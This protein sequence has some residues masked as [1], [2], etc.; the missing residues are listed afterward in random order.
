[1]KNTRALVLSAMLSVSALPL[2]AQNWTPVT[3]TKLGDVSGQLVSSGKL[4]FT[5]TDTNDAPIGVQIGGGGQ[6]ATVEV[7]A[8]VTNGVSTVGFQI[9]NPAHTVPAGVLYRI[10]LHDSR[11]DIRI[12]RRVPVGTSFNLDNYSEPASVVPLTGTTITGPFTVLGDFSVTGLCTGCGTGGGGGSGIWGGI[13][14]TLT[15]QGDLAAALALKAPL[16]SAALTGTPTAPTPSTAD[17]TTK[18]ATTAFVKAQGYLAGTT[19][20]PQTKTLIASQWLNAYDATTG[21]LTA[22]QPAFTNLSGLLG[23]TQMPT[24]TGDV[25]NTNCGMT[26]Q[27][28]AITFA[29]IAAATYLGTGTKLLSTSATAPGSPKCA[30]FAADGTIGVAGTGAPCGSGGTGMANP[31]TTLGDVIYGGAA[32]APARLAGNTTTTPLVYQSTGSAGVATAPT[33]GTIDYSQATIINKPTI[34]ADVSGKKYII[35]TPDGALPNAQSLSALATCVLKNTTTTGVLSCALAGDIPNIAESQ[36]T[37]LTT[38][39]AAKVPTSTT[40]N[41]HAL[42]AN[43]TVTQTDVGL[44]S[45]TNDVQ[46]KAA[47]VPNTL[48]SAGQ[49]PV[50]NAGNTAYVPVTVSGDGTLT[51]AGV[52]ALKNSGVSAASYTNPNITVDAQGR[53]TTASNG[54]GGGLFTAANNATMA[55]GT[56]TTTGTCTFKTNT[57][58]Q[59]EADCPIKTP[60]GASNFTSFNNTSPVANDF[61]MYL[62]NFYFNNGTSTKQFAFIDSA[63]TGNSAT[64]TALAANGTNCSAGQAPLGVDASGNAEGCWTP[65]GSG[66]VNS[67]TIN[68][69]AYYAG[70]GTA[71]SGTGALP[72]GTTAATQ[73]AGD[74]ST[75]VSTTA[76]VDT[77]LALKAPL[78]SPT[79]TGT[80]AAPTAAPGTN[81]TQLATTAF[82]AA[83]VTGSSA[84]PVFPVNSQTAN[85]SVLAG[86]FSSCKHITMNNAGATTVTL[87]ATAPTTGQCISV[88]NIGAGT[89]TISRNGLNIDGA[90]SNVSITT[91]QSVDIISDGSNYFTRRGIGGGGSSGMTINGGSTAT[92]LSDSTPAAPIAT[93]PGAVNVNFQISGSNG[94]GYVN[95]FMQR[96]VDRRFGLFAETGTSYAFSGSEAQVES[97][98][99]T[100]TAPSSSIPFTYVQVATGTTISTIAGIRGAV[101]WQ[102]GGSGHP[103]NLYFA[104]RVALLDNASGN[105]RICVGLL[106]SSL[107]TSCGSD[108][109]VAHGAW[110]RFSTAVDVTNWY[111]VTSDGSTVNPVSAATS[112]VADANFHKLEIAMDDSGTG[113]VHFFIDGT[114]VCGSG[115]TSNLPGTTTNLAAQSSIWNL[116]GANR[117]LQTVGLYTESNY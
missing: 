30:E 34:P 61:W 58:N 110:F 10:R 65:T 78:A 14:G 107:G 109:P 62:N 92:N 84:A 74:N 23:C 6:A 60:A 90:A 48:P 38:D 100:H 101:A 63:M 82:V 77:G 26:I 37:N 22:S 80:P 114:Q 111:C 69:L 117:R 89:T 31:M 85:Y 3:A 18:V 59:L 47:I 64:A 49:I 42:S 5:P 87:L 44:S 21:L 15:N 99:A 75:K 41:G 33:L 56:K 55:A 50:G 108:T 32:G 104:S 95:G 97:L 72:S 46:T 16:D 98:L 93:K 102:R 25:A 20:L 81:T 96:Y 1:M 27:A 54:T 11:G 17:N 43:V 88:G 113:T 45:V 4:C 51:S 68:Q 71:V 105:Q 103:T 83:A 73:T 53:I 2:F 112:A 9:P 12:W 86:D 29:K 35:Q 8:V 52:L 67:G 36:V 94:S 70:A 28:N 19:V 7:C 13:T 40:V 57:T 79:F 116:T 24:F 106:S 66:T 76:Y 91:N 115:L 39:L